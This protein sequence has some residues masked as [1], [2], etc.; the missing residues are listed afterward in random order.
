MR[1]LVLVLFFLSAAS[2]IRFYMAP[3]GQKCFSEDLG[4]G[5]LINGYT[6][7]VQVLDE[8]TKEF[9]IAFTVFNPDGTSLY[10]RD[11]VTEDKTKFAFSSK[12]YGEHRFCF[13][14]HFQS[15]PN[16]EWSRIIEFD[17]KVG[18]S[19][20]DYRQLAMKQHLDPLHVEVQYALDMARD[21]HA[22]AM[23]LRDREA[24]MRDTSEATNSRVPRFTI[25]FIMVIV[26]IS[27]YEMLYI[28]KFL[29]HEKVL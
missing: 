2:A 22:Q 26:G 23:Y 15:D 19:G 9:D 20:R 5:T 29:H 28:K 25:F 6:H 18:Q 8:T 21:V 13:I 1:F 7:D 11:L 27:I 4:K 17:Y 24:N 3:N 10:Q 14:S 16:S 12:S